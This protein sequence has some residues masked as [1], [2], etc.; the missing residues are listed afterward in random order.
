MGSDPG[1]GPARGEA[2]GNESLFHKFFEVENF[3]GVQN[4]QMFLVAEQE[5][6][7]AV[8][9]QT[10]V[11]MVLYGDGVDL[12]PKGQQLAQGHAH[13]LLSEIQIKAALAAALVQCVVCGSEYYIHGPKCN[14]NLD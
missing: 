7:E 8:F 1:H 9:V 4:Q 13:Q 2:Q 3:Q 5:Y 12:F 14:I 10:A 6:L 11:K